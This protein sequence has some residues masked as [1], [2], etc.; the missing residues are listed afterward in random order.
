MTRFLNGE[1]IATLISGATHLPK[2]V[3]PSSLHL[4]ARQVFQLTGAGAVDFGGSEYSEAT[5]ELIPVVKRSP[6]DKYGWWDL[7]QGTYLLELNESLSLPEGAIGLLIPSQRITSGGASHPVQ[8]ITGSCEQ[9]VAPLFV[10]YQGMR[11]KQNARVS[12][13]LVFSSF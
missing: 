7:K 3:E 5:R 1:Q 12:Q 11:I 2:Q 13:L 6:D 4:T 9:I 8:L 10:P